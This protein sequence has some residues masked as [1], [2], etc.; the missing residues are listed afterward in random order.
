MNIKKSFFIKPK[1]SEIL[2]AGI[3]LYVR[4]SLIYNSQYSKPQMECF[5]VKIYFLMC[6]SKSHKYV[7]FNKSIFFN[8]NKC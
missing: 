1:G 2:S 6:L 7:F 3:M 5:Y 8:E 4:V